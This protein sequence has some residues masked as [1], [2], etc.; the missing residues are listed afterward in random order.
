MVIINN[1][2]NN[3]ITG[4]IILI[5]TI[6]VSKHSAYEGKENW[7]WMMPDT[8]SVGEVDSIS[9]ER[10]HTRTHAN[11]HAHIHSHAHTHSQKV[12]DCLR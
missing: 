6:I 10:T 8:D 9:P 7:L 1:C 2:G 12:H 5:I 4:A 11:T 3:N